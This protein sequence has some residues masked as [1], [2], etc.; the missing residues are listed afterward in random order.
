MLTR[1]EA[2]GRVS[3][4]T[5]GTVVSATAAQFPFFSTAFEKR[6]SALARLF[7]SRALPGQVC[8]SVVEFAAGPVHSKSQVFCASGFDHAAPPFPASTAG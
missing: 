3:R 1:S 4:D 8:T 6:T 2:F 5:M 7:W